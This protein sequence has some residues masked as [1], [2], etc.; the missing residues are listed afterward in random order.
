MTAAAGM[1][2]YEVSN[3]ARPGQEA[4]HNLIYW[5]AGDWAAV[6]PGAHGRLTLPR[7][8]HRDRGAP[9]T[10]AMAGGGDRWP[11]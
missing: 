5:R 3:H 8:P 1:P 6:G 10:G 4:R 11:G 9:R 2:A 7:R